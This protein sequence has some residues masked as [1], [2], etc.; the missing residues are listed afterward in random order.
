MSDRAIILFSLV[1]AVLCQPKS[2]AS[3]TYFQDVEPIIWKNCA[4]CHRENGAAPFALLTFDQVSK[5]AG[6]IAEVVSHG[7]MPPWMPDTAYSRFV[8]ERK[9]TAK[10]KSLIEA[11]VS[12]GKKKGKR[13]KS[14]SIPVSLKD[15]LKEDLV[16]EV[17]T[18]NVDTNVTD[19]YRFYVIPNPIR[20]DTTIT[21]IRF[22]AGNPK[23]VHHAWVFADTV[24]FNFSGL[25][26]NVVS[27][28]SD[29]G[30][31]FTDVLTGYL[32][33]FTASRLPENTGK[34]FYSGSNVVV[35]V[36][37]YSP[38]GV[39]RDSS[40]ISFEFNREPIEIPVKTKLILEKNLVDPPLFLPANEVTTE[41]LEKHIE[42]SI[43]I[44]RIGPHMHARGKKVKVYSVTPEFDTIPLIR[45]NDWDFNWQGYY[46]FQK[47]VLVP[48][49]SRIIQEATYDNTVGNSANPVKPPVDVVYGLGSLNEMC[50]MALEYVSLKSDRKFL[51]SWFNK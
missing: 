29:L 12:K 15:E 37:Y 2:V 43:L 10:E 39:F 49:G 23:I 45:I 51:D 27:E 24:G 34:R 8:G 9:L 44:L 11:W 1:A 22:N 5:K 40:S 26:T 16:I 35:Q 6:T 31:P 20:D 18:L 48:A 14:R 38:S 21:A 33:G 4:P 30:F 32:P 3:Q 47:P 25:P 7:F 17:G 13:K 42:D 28:F 50:E 36:H 46:T 41:V 19:L